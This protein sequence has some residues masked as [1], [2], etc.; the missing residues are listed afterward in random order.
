MCHPE[1]SAFF[2][3]DLQSQCPLSIPPNPPFQ[4]D[5]NFI[6]KALSASNGI[7]H[8]SVLFYASWCPFSRTTLSKFETLS[9][10]FPQIEHF[11]LEQSSALPS[12]FSRYGIHSLPAILLVNQTRSLRYRG[13]K[14][15]LSLVQFYE[16]NTGFKRV[17]YFADDQQSSFRSDEETAMK[18]LTNLSLKEISSREPYLAFSI[19]FICLRILLSVLPEVVSRLQAF[20]ASYVPH[21][22][23]QIFGETSQ[24]MG[25]VLHAIDVR[26]IWTEL[27]LCK[28]RVLHERARCAQ[29]WA[30]SLASVSLGESSSSR[31]S[32]S[33]S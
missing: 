31:C 25:R 26:R 14:D 33:L 30:S 12:V 13:A 5:G 24:A 1:D 8:M 27:R 19:L 17:D 32:S 7:G 23:L 20:W 22:N 3:Y 6:E 4:V 15:L 28:T 21:L 18:S 29:V 16:K 10:M 11:I 9:S 2:P